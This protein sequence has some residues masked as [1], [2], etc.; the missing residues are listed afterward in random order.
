MMERKQLYG[1]GSLRDLQ[2]T[3]GKPSRKAG[4][5]RI[6]FVMNNGIRREVELSENG[7][8]S[9]LTE[10][11]RWNSTSKGYMRYSPRHE[12]KFTSEGH[13]GIEE[14]MLN[15]WFGVWCLVLSA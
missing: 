11:W 12:Q 13:F 4:R 8:N 15:C 5:Y 2:G 1:S 3:R 7:F 9:S 14:S 10:N 6:G